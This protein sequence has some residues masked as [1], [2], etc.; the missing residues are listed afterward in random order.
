[1]PAWWRQRRGELLA[2]MQDRDAAY[3]YDTSVVAARARAVRALPG[4]SRALYAMKANPSAALLRAAHAAGLGIE[5]VSRGEIEAARKAIPALAPEQILFTPNFAPRAEYEWA[6]RQGVQV[7]VDNLYVLAHWPELFRDREIFVRIDP[8]AGRGHHHHVRTGG[9][10]SKFGVPAEEADQLAHLARAAGASVVGLHA[11]VGSGIFGVDSWARTA[12]SLREVAQR[13]PKVRVFDLG[14]GFGVPDRTGKPAFDLARLGQQLA[15]LKASLGSIEIWVEPGRYIVAESG[16]LLARVTQTKAK[17]DV[18]YVGI[19][20]GMNS[21][22]RPALYGAYHEIHN[23]T[24]LDEAE[25]E[26]VNVVGPICESGDYLGHDRALPA[27][28]E[29][30]ILLIAAAG[31]YGAAMSSHYNLREPAGEIAL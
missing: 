12:E 19:A 5:C 2:A 24:R 31:A 4:I 20:T 11:H 28:Q 22:I 27:T 13:F 26:L 30:D 17:G 18:R 3:V 21:L 16:V 25:T 9:S 29:G 8:G 15:Q 10:Y 1:V 7:T 23:L 14:G 6:L